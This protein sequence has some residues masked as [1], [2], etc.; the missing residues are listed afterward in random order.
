MRP[1]VLP[2]LQIDPEDTCKK[3]EA[4][5]GATQ[6]VRMCGRAVFSNAIDEHTSKLWHK[7]ETALE[8]RRKKKHLAR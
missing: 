4:Q 7:H 5:T 8:L 1:D 3:Q 2:F 6:R